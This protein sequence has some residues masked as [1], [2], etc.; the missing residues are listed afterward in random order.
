MYN[1]ECTVVYNG[2]R[3]LRVLTCI[4]LHGLQLVSGVHIER[5]IHLYG[6]YIIVS[7]RHFVVQAFKNSYSSLEQQLIANL[8]IMTSVSKH[9]SMLSAADFKDC[10]KTIFCIDNVRALSK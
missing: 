1:P 7:R 6:L 9:P 8:Q 10:S 4:C 3:H 5:N 2:V